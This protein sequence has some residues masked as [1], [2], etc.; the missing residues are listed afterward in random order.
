LHIS[1]V[2]QSINSNYWFSKL[3]PLATHIRDIS[4]SVYI[5][6]SNVSIDEMISRFSGRSSHTFRIKNKPTPQGYKILSLCDFG[7][8]YSFIFLSRISHHPNIE[9]IPGLNKTSCEVWYLVE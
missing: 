7:Y 6:A 5:P 3:E 9:I 2:T 8:T 1:D 4:K